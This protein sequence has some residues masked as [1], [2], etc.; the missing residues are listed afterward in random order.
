MCKYNKCPATNA[1]KMKGNVKCS[2][3]NLLIVAELTEKFPHT[4][5][6]KDL[7]IQ[8]IALNRF[9]MTVAPHKLI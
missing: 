2:E 8:G 6:T 3:K 5:S 9:V 4:N 7:P 1:A